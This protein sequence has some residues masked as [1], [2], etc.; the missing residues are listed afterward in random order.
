MANFKICVRKKRTDNLYPVYIR[1]THH[2][3]TAYIKTEKVVDKSGIRKGEVKDTEVLSYC[4]NLIKAYNSKL[5]QKDISLWTV[6]KVVN[7]LENED[8]DISFSDYARKYIFEMA[9]LRKMERNSKNYKWAYQSLER[10]ANNENIMFSRL[11]S[12]FIQDWIN[13][14]ANTNR[15]KEMYP[16]CIR[17][18]FNAALEEFNDYDHDIIRIKTNPFRKIEIPKA[19][20][21]TKRALEIP[22]LQAFFNGSMP[23]TKYLSSR[24]EISRDV[25][26]MVFCLVGMNTAD[27]YELKKENL[28]GDL[29]CYH[30][31]KTKKHR[32]D[33][34][35]LEIKIPLRIQHLFEKYKSDNEYLLNFNYRYQDSNTFNTNVNGGLKVYCKA[36]NLPPICIYNFRHSWA[37]I[38]QNNCHASTEE[39]GFALNHSSAHRITEGYIKKDYSPISVLNEKVITCVFGNCLQK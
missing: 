19:D 7:F 24:T 22:V 32:S 13:S 15:A 25:A 18:I 23:M 17:M 21:P 4:T 1:I 37:T 10:F 30:R 14:L 12:K 9:S 2:R 39:V 27:L 33:G 20:T 26:E 34:A 5:N 35:Y 8:K 11:T 29:L 31:Q 28:K 38:A 3:K 36:N 6:N 16:I